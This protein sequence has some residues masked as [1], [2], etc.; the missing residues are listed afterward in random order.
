[1]GI[2]MIIFWS[3]VILA[4]ILLATG[5][6]TNRRPSNNNA[7]GA[8]R[9]ILDQRYARGEIDHGQYEVMKR[10]LEQRP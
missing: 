6:V 1:M 5:A 7:D 4:V 8:A 9:E 2:I 10:N 3:M